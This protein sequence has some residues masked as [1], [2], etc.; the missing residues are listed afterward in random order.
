MGASQAKRGPTGPRVHGRTGAR[1]Q[2]S[3]GG[4]GAEVPT[5]PN[6][7]HMGSALSSRQSMMIS[8]WFAS[9]ATI[10]GV[11]PGR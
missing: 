4:A 11:W 10:N 1:A 3:G 2:R 8:G 9:A 5:L 7:A 6:E